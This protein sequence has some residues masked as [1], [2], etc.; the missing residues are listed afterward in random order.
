MNSCIHFARFALLYFLFVLIFQ[1][2]GC[3]TSRTGMPLIDAVYN[4]QLESAK[5]HVEEGADI[6]QRDRRGYTPLMA[7]T[8]HNLFCMAE[9]LLERGADINAQSNDGRTV[10][11]L[12]T[13]NK[14]I[15]LVK[16]LLKYSPDVT[17]VDNSGRTALAHAKNLN[18]KVISELIENQKSL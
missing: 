7:A 6:N 3:T 16:L 11:M 9:Y 18:L 10:L 14:N 8:Y 13:C 2:A 17:I 12:A 5:R 15:R 1:C 4:N